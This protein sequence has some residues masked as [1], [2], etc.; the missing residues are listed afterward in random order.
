MLHF[1]PSC[2]NYWFPSNSERGGNRQNQCSNNLL[3]NSSKLYNKP[4]SNDC[5]RDHDRKPAFFHKAQ[6]NSPVWDSAPTPLG[7]SAGHCIPLNQGFHAMDMRNPSPESL[8]PRRPWI[9]AHEQAAGRTLW[10]TAWL[11]LCPTGFY[12]RPLTYA[13]GQSGKSSW[14]FS[15]YLL[16]S[17]K[18]QARLP[19]RIATLTQRPWGQGTARNHTCPCANSI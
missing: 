12:S 3:L 10:P 11:E 19:A 14:Q 5:V 18:D 7:V 17:Q 9:S 13:H 1:A 15:S 2:I 8:T 16:L 4:S 6:G